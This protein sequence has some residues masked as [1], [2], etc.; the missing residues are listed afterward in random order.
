MP[1]KLHNNGIT[2]QDDGDLDDTTVDGDLT[3]TGDVEVG[4]TGTLKAFTEEIHF[5]GA[6]GSKSNRIYC[7]ETTDQTNIGLNSDLGRQL[8]ICDRDVVE[9]DFGHAVPT[10]PTL[11]IQSALDPDTN[12]TRWGSF[13]HTGD[14]A[15]A[16]YFDYVLGAGV[17]RFG[18]AGVPGVATAV[19]DVFVNGAFEVDGAVD[20][21]ST[22]DVAGAVNIVSILDVTG[23]ASLASTFSVGGN[24]DFES[25]VTVSGQLDVDGAVDFGSALGVDGAVTFNS[26]LDVTGGT[27]T[28]GSP[29]IYL[30][31]DGKI[32]T[33]GETAPDCAAGGITLDINA[34]DGIFFSAKSSDIAHALASYGETDTFY[35]LRKYDG[36]GGGTRIRSFADGDEAHPVGYFVETF[37]ENNADTVTGKAGYGLLNFYAAQ[38]DGAG[39]LVD[40]ADAGNAFSIRCRKNNASETK[41]LLK[42]N[43][44]FWHAGSG[45]IDGGLSTGGETAPDCEDGGITLNMGAND[46]IFLS[47]KSSDIAHGLTAYAETDT[48]FTIN[49]R[50]AAGG[51]LSMRSFTDGGEGEAVGWSV[52]TF[53]RDTLDTTTSVAG[54]GGINFSVCQHDGSNNKVTCAA[55]GNLFTVR[56]WY[57]SGGG[58]DWEVAFIIKG[59]GDIYYDGADQ[60]AFDAEQ[61]ALAC[62]DAAYTIAGEFDKVLAYNREE[63]ER[64][65]V[66]QNGFISNRKMTKLNLFGLAEVYAVVE[67]LCEK[68]GL[69]YEDIRKEIRGLK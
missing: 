9:D 19:N 24:A 44:D 7:D 20:F 35:S 38:H 13:S 50:D 26:T 43:G 16:G 53:I 42:G 64:I 69:S 55:N 17:H 68:F 4:S 49:K 12:N 31:S 10:N 5:G 36:D 46:G 11:F 41:F 30:R 1:L 15:N 8:V 61:D 23:A 59:D 14:A 62:R 25:D 52:S 51:G 39:N 21:G 33:G 29:A 34:N 3:I 54:L 40:V 58:A 2:I 27:S 28:F 63:L 22:L 47:A 67:K 18:G 57:N 56:R 37:V 6:D 65:G 32:S 45:V 60:G 48:F 66:M